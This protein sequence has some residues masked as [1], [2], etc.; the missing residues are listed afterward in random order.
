VDILTALGL[1]L[2]AGLN[3]YIPLLGLAL[4]QRFGVLA[5]RNP[6]SGIG[7]WWV[8]GLISALLLI[9]FFADKIP[10]VDHLNDALQSFVRPAAGAV[11]ALAASGQAGENYPVAMVALGVILAGG[12]HIAKASARPVVNASTAG[13]GAPVVSLLEDFVAAASTVL[14]ILAPVLVVALAIVFVYAWWRLRS[15]RRARSAG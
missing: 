12:V 4:A 8:I 6:W 15:I 13:V 14:A 1:A 3:A 11:V 9:E 2:P 10:A 7:E 5:L